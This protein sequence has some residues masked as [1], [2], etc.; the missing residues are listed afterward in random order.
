MVQEEKEGA[1]REGHMKQR[2]SYHNRSG[3]MRDS[4]VCCVIF[5]MSTSFRFLI[6]F[7]V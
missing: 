3:G 6:N 4:G 7:F 5:L 1:Y 2:V